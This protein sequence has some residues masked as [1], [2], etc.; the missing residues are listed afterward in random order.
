MVSA[1][2]T[3]SKIGSTTISIL[4]F[5]NWNY[6]EEDIQLSRL[7]DRNGLSEADAKKRIA[8]Q[9]ALEKKCEMSH[10]VIENSSSTSD[11]EEQTLKILE[12][13]LESN[14]HWRIRGY[15]L[16]TAAVFLS[17]VAWL[18]NHKYKIFSD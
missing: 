18:L 13:L 7:M 12:V 3:R 2:S 1:Y 17:G 6:S 14:H 15:I 4:S 16:A 11:T 5:W 8:A 10:F 9:M